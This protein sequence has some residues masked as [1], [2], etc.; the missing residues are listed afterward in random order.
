MHAHHAQ[1]WLATLRMYVIMYM[2]GILYVYG[3]N[4]PGMFHN[5]T[6]GYPTGQGETERYMIPMSGPGDRV[7]PSMVL[8]RI[9]GRD[10]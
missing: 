8:F 2:D 9:A 6:L 10:V 3:W 1:N 5:W 7:N 4:G